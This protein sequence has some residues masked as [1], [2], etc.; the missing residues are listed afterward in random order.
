MTRYFESLGPSGIRMM[1]Q[2]ASVQVSVDAGTNPID[3]WTLLNALAPY[4]VATFSNS[5][6]YAG[7][8]TGHQ[9]Y[10]A[11]L[12]RTLDPSRTGLAAP[13]SRPVGEYALFALNA[14]AMFSPPRDGRYQTFLEWMGDGERSTSDWDLHVSTLFP[15][16]RPK[17]FFEVRSPDMIDT[18]MIAAP[19]AFIA[20]LVY[21][22]RTAQAAS[23]L[24]SENAADLVTAGRDGLRGNDIAAVAADLADLA[25]AGCQSLGEGYVSET[26]LDTL[27]EFVDR[28][29]RNGKS[30]ADDQ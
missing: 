8:A 2:T 21:D 6:R 25:I 5:S 3:R 9:S 20:G 11:H 14:G 28:Y 18:R 10:R 15:E 27:V 1:R 17:G 13:S 12:W 23:Q 30:P 19:I 7:T 16:V 24:L 26:D 29:T 4:L 22:D